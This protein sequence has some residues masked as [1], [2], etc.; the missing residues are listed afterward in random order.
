MSQQVDVEF[1]SAGFK[2]ILESEGVHDFLEQKANEIKSRADANI[3]DDSEGFKVT[4]MKGGYGGGRWVAHVQTTDYATM[5]AESEHKAL[6]K[7]V[8]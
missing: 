1:I 8:R 7:A 6:T 5:V 3:G 2:E 4:V